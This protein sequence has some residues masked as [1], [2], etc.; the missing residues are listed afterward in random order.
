MISKGDEIIDIIFSYKLMDSFVG[1][2]IKDGK[3]Y[4]LD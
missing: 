1:E 2:A 4:V 3:L